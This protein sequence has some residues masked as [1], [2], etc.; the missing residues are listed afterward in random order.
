M[1]RLGTRSSALALWQ[2]RHVAEKL[3]QLDC[4]I[5]IIEVST[6]G[7]RDLRRPISELESSAPFADDIELALFRN[8]I[9]LAVHSLKD[10]SVESHDGLV[11]AAVLKRGD[12]RETLVSGRNVRLVDLPSGAV[13]GTSSPRRVAQIK[14]LRSDLRTVPIRGPVDDRVRQVRRGD[15]DGA[16][17]A[18]AG[19]E[20]LGLLHEAT[21][22]F[23]LNE[24]VPA[25]AQ[26]ALAVQARADSADL[27]RHISLLN[28]EATHAAVTAEL[29][30]LRPFESRGD[31]VAAA[32]AFSQDSICLHSR[33]LTYSGEIHCDMVLEGED[34]Y[35]LA[36]R[37]LRQASASPRLMEV[38]T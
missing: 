11:I 34:P 20:R 9:D 5:E 23:P 16:V 7:D 18:A 10:L 33:L 4:D 19:L 12:P 14:H 37:A 2:A 30:F 28:D 15:F 3:R 25:P 6:S 21:E 13:I 31:V 38:D 36:A 17:L 1:I 8:D 35:E 32:Y 26:S 29:E 22:F 24:F 27:V